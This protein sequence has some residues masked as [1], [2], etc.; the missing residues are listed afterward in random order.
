MSTTPSYE[1]TIQAI[2]EACK[3]TNISFITDEDDGRLS[4]AVKEKPY[5]KALVE[6]LPTGFKTE[7]PKARFWYD[8]IINGIPV[9]L[10]LTT[11]K[12][13][14]AFNKK[15][16]NATLACGGS[17]TTNQNTD[18][19]A[20]YENLK[21]CSKNERNLATEYHYLAI[22]KNTGEILLKPLLDIHSYK[23]NPSN[24]MQINWKN[25]F[26]NIAYRSPDYKA[27][28]RE[29]LKTIQTSL[30]EW[31]ERSKAFVEAD[32]DADFA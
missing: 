13:D 31:F 1:E 32:I 28:V 23:T 17:I 6:N 12:A 30:K 14:N 3:K 8:I 25:E 7:M 16:V 11:G 27:K 29:L 5:L 20:F 4:S 19:N 15:A 24:I 9:N 2:K 21:K 18:F 26:N 22:H 10:K